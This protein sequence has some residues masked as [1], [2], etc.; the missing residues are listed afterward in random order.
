AAYLEKAAREA[1]THTSW[2]S[3]DA[4][5]EQRFRAFGEAVLKND[6]FRA[7]LLR[8]QK[9][10]AFHGFLNGLAQVVLKI[11][12]PG[13]PDFYQ[14]TELWDF[15]LVDP[16]N[17]RPVDYAKRAA[18]LRKLKAAHGRGTLDVPALARRWTDGR[19]KL[20]VTWRA[21]DTR[22]RH[23]EA[24]RRGAY[25]PLDAG[26]NAIAFLRG[27]GLLVAVPRLTAKLTGPG[28]APLGEAWGD[29]TVAAA[30]QWRNVF[31]GEELGG[32]RLRLADLFATFPVALL[33]K[34]GRN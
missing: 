27:D 22:A 34:S 29:A 13:V 4:G 7:S 12:S 6:E 2:I 23:A 3:P 32:E 26:P 16:D 17:R 20:F 9:R 28:K 33:E 30:G 15:S 11:A 5:F 25:T 18:M 1:K 14:G 31:T 21:L 10:V 24:F 19:V 8:F